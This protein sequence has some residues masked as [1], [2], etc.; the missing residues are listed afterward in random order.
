MQDYAPEEYNQL[1]EFV[2]AKWGQQGG[3]D[4]A[5]DLK[6]SQ[7][8]VKDVELSREQA[9]DEIIA[10]STY[11]MLQDEGFVDELCK[12]HRGV[13]TGYFGCNK[14]GAPQAACRYC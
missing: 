3:I 9:L 12:T 8:A 13:A 6:V 4:D 1:K 14:R 7:Y 5:V 10:D 11:E 2:R